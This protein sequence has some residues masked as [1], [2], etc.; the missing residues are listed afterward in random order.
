MF[1]ICSGLLRG[2]GTPSK[3]N[4]FKKRTFCKL[5]PKQKAI[6]S[7]LK[8]IAKQQSCNTISKLYKSFRQLQPTFI[9]KLKNTIMES[10]QMLDD[11]PFVWWFILAA[12][13]IAIFGILFSI[14]TIDNTLPGEKESTPFFK[15]FFNRSFK[16]KS[17]PNQN[18][19]NPA[20]RYKE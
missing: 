10:F 14:F 18:K 15:R 5:N 13:L 6:K 4:Y 9:A 11:Y 19:D 12:A 1:G 7:E 17:I 16:R 3:P 20:Q 2:C 8:S